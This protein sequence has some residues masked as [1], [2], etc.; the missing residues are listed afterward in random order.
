M[1]KIISFLKK[2]IKDRKLLKIRSN[3]VNSHHDV[4]EYDEKKL[5][6]YRKMGFSFSE[7]SLFDLKNND[8]RDY[9]STWESYQPRLIDNSNFIISDD[10]YLFSL[11]FGNYVRTPKTICLIKK[12]KLFFAMIIFQ[13]LAN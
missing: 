10:K 5:A 13:A 1:S 11:V 12:V 4:N 7:S 2:K 8:W 9:I 6:D 3:I